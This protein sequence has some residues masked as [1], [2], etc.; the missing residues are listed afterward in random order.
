MEPH[1]YHNKI[2]TLLSAFLLLLISCTC[3]SEREQ[4]LDLSDTK[5]DNMVL[6][7]NK[8]SSDSYIKDLSTL[9]AD[10]KNNGYM[11]TEARLF[12]EYNMDNEGRAEALTFDK[13]VSEN[14]IWVQV[15]AYKSPSDALRAFRD[16]VD[17]WACCIPDEDIIRLKNLENLEMFKNSNITAWYS[18]Q[19]VVFSTSDSSEFTTLLDSFFSNKEFLKLSV[20]HTGPA[21]WSMN[22]ISG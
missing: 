2:F 20:G 16:L 6:S 15:V 22:N 14:N 10:L 1:T 19:L 12:R 5:L 8:E 13:N 4:E 18:E 3:C 17:F 9:R 7:A 21:E 11:E